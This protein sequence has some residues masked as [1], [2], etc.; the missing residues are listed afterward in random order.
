MD[1]SRPAR[2]IH[3][4]IVEWSDRGR[5]FAVAVVLA[6]EGSTPR[7]AGT[8]AIVDPD[9]TIHGTV[10]GGRVEAEVQRRARDAIRSGRPVVFDFDLLGQTAS[11]GEP[12]CGGRMRLLIDPTAP[13]HRGAYAA[14]AMARDRRERGL[15]VTTVRGHAAPDVAVEFHGSRAIPPEHEFP[16]AAALEAV[17]AAE[18][19]RHFACEAGQCRE[20]LEA[21][22]EPLVPTP[23]LLIAGG[24]HI[25]QALAAQ[26]TLV[27][28]GVTVIDDRAEFTR[29]ELFPEGT[30]TRC[31]DIGEEVER[32]PFDAGTYAV[33][34]TRDHAHDADAL[35]ACL[36]RPAAY[37]GMIGSRGKVT[38]MR[39]D[40]IES[41]R[42]TAAAFDRVYAPI[43]L[44]I[45]SRT[46]P[47]IAASI[48]AQ[49]VAVRRT[50]HAPRIPLG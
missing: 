7:K 31:G 20:P 3:R 48:V 43:G 38:L 36:D 15:L 50:G 18:E 45:G 26:A 27:G 29:P 34:V 33:I 47:E 17:L 46:V 44:D 30:A 11:G 4:T 32:F 8:K 12:I 14:A 24:G 23:V 25:G 6:A 37:V 16:G 9:G 10:G 40:L 5:A 22:V 41:G 42:A 13:R 39:Q 19:A 28:F 49:L 35:A 1:P 21:L 2:D